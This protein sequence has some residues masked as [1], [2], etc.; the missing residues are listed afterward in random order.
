MTRRTRRAA[1]ASTAAPD[2]QESVR[3]Y[4]EASVLKPVSPSTH[5]DNWP[6]FL[7]SNATVHRHDGSLANQLEVDL[8][9]PFIIRG[10]LELEKD[11]E[12]YLVNRQLKTEALWIQIESS[13]TFS[14]GAKDDSLSVPVVW[15]SG[16]AGWFEIVPAESYQRICDIM[17]QGVCLHYSFLD[18]YEAA[19]EKLQ[20]SKKKKKATLAD[21]S[22][23]LDELLFQY[24][25]LAGDGLTLP[26]AYKRLDQQCIFFLSHFP[27]DTGVFSYLANKFPNPAQQLANKDTKDIRARMKAIPGPCPLKAYDYDGSHREKS[28]SLEMADRKNKG[29]ERTKISAPRTTRTSEAS[30]VELAILPNKTHNRQPYKSTRMKRRSPAEIPLEDDIVMID[31]TSDNPTPSRTSH[32]HRG[33]I[34]NQK[35]TVDSNTTVGGKSSAR[36]LVDALEDVKRQMLQLIREGSQKKQLDQI[37]AKSWQ[38]KVYMECN[39][40]HY[41]ST[42]EIFHYHARELVQCL[43]PEWHKTQIYQWIKEIASKPPTLT[44]ISEAEVTQIV[45]RVKKAGRGARTE[46]TTSENPQIEVREYAGKQTPRGRPSG[47]AAGLRPST[48][49]KKRLRYDVDFEDKMD[50]DEDGI[51]KKKSKRSHYFTEEDDD[52][53]DDDDDDGVD[54]HNEDSSSGSKPHG[55][56]ND[57]PVT[58]FIIRAEKLPSTQPQ[59]P[60]KTWICEEHDCGYI[61]RAAHE[62]KGRKLISAHYEKHEK[63]AQDVAQETA[64]DRENLAVQ[65]GTRGHMPINHL[66]EKIRNLGGK[67]KQRNEPHINGRVVP[68]PIKRTLFI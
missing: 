66:L 10:R 34:Q 37:T 36:V 23:D 65:E 54:E 6:C 33:E 15:A 7:L 32:D 20:K 28:S 29:K 68:E 59:G 64:L 5:T 45:R 9:G 26:E 67:S 60:N 21:V 56:K 24:A 41:G 4:K 57:I 50:L 31:S 39:I 14:V 18:Q 3:H 48:G 49:S 25:L 13:H 52:D 38:T 17:F 40:K 16:G 1:S 53:D 2:Y 47:K 8:Q 44:L 51:L 19:L 46:H 55:E 62:E 42:G 22:L 63:E 61:V 43:G 30:D 12:R 11:N 58:Q 35:S 27:K